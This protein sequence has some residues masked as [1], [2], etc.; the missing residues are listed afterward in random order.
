MD[1]LLSFRALTADVVQMD[2]QIFHSELRVE[3]TRCLFSRPQNVGHIREVVGLAYPLQVFKKV[4]GRVKDVEVVV[5]VLEHLCHR[6]V[7]CQL[8]DNVRHPRVEGFGVVGLEGHLIVGNELKVVACDVHKFRDQVVLLQGVDNALD[9][10]AD[11]LEHEW[12]VH[13]LLTLGEAVLVDNLNLL[14]DGRLTRLTGT[15][16]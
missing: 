8:L 2:I 12:L 4:V 5:W 1:P 14:Q 13:E 9:R 10:L 11:V 15:Q 16:K 7:G 6:R 3:N